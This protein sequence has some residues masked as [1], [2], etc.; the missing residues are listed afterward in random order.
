MPRTRKHLALAL[1]L[2]RAAQPALA[3]I[4]PAPTPAA[5]GPYQYCN[6]I[7][8]GTQ[9]RDASLEYGQHPK[10]LTANPEME[11]LN[12]KVKSLDSAVL[13]LN[14]L[15]SHGWEYVAVTAFSPGTS[16]YS[17]YLLRRRVQ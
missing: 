4:T 7:G 12:E 15:T 11:A 1:G 8:Y 14:Y 10:P 13:A 17:L 2:A 5:A 3:Q 16:A 6:L 9:G